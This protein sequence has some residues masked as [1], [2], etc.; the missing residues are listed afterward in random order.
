MPFGG[1]GLPVILIGGV[2]PSCLVGFASALCRGSGRV[3]LYSHAP[4]SA[5]IFL[6]DVGSVH[7]G[8][9]YGSKQLGGGVC[10]PLLPGGLLSYPVHIKRVIGRFCYYCSTKKSA[11]MVANTILVF[12]QVGLVYEERYYY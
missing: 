3:T 9:R 10:T 1:V 5:L 6:L 12:V 7:L 4:N 11:R 2:V 8:T